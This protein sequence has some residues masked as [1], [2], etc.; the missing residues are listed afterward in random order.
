MRLATSRLMELLAVVA[1]AL[2][3]SGSR[4]ARLHVTV[5]TQRGWVFYF[6]RTT[7]FK[8]LRNGSFK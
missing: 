3:S 8:I 5:L 4:D 2:G 1:E 7:T 6:L